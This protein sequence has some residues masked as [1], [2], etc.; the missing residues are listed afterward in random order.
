LPLGRA[1]RIPIPDWPAHHQRDHVHIPPEHHHFFPI[2]ITN[3]NSLDE[4]IEILNIANTITYLYDTNYPTNTWRLRGGTDYDFPTNISLNAGAYLL[5]VNFDPRT[6]LTQL[7]AFRSL[8]S[9]PAGV[10]DF[11]SLPGDNLSNSGGTVEL[12][13]PDPVQLP[14]IRCGVCALHP[15]G[16]GGIQ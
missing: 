11:R 2:L 12:D 14:P 15:R 16:T 3:D 5:A 10:A 1:A 4:Y 7:A 8:Y 6:N 13:K 9:V